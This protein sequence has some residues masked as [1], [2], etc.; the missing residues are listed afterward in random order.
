MEERDEFGKL[1]EFDLK[2]TLVLHLPTSNITQEHLQVTYGDSSKYSAFFGG[3]VTLASVSVKKE[4]FAPGFIEAELQVFVDVNRD[5]L[6]RM[7]GVKAELHNSKSGIAQHYVIFNVSPRYEA[8]SQQSTYIKLFIYSPDKLLSFKKYNKCYVAK[9]FGADIFSTVAKQAG[10]ACDCTGLQ[11]LMLTNGKEF[12]QPYL[13][14]YDETA[15]HF[16]TRVANRCGEFMYYENGRWKLG[17]STQQDEKIVDKYSSRTYHCFKEES[18]ADYW[19][20]NYI[21][22]SKGSKSQTAAQMTEGMQNYMGPADENMI[23]YEAKTGNYG[24]YL[25]DMDFTFPRFYVES[26]T[27]WLK[28]DNLATTIGTMTADLAVLL[29]QEGI[30][31]DGLEKSWNDD[32]MQPFLTK[33]EHLQGEG[34]DAKVAPFTNPQAVTDGFTHLFYTAVKACGKKAENGA[35]HLDLGKKYQ[36][37]RLGDIITVGGEKYVVT[38]MELACTMKQEGTAEHASMSIDALPQVNRSDSKEKPDLQWYPEPDDDNYIRKAEPQMAVVTT[39]HNADPMEL[40]RIQI[41]YPWQPTD[42]TP[43][44]PWIRVVA[45]FTSKDAAVRFA[46]KPGNEIMVGYEYGDIERPFMMGALESTENHGYMP[47]DFKQNPYIIATPNGHRITFSNPIPKT[48]GDPL[49]GPMF[50]GWKLLQNFLPI[51][52]KYKWNKAMTSWISDQLRGGITMTDALGFYKIAMSTTNRSVTI[53]SALGKVDLNALTGITI[54]APNGNVK[55][56]GKNVEITAGNNLKLTSGTNIKK[57]KFY[58]DIKGSFVSNATGAFAGGV[59]SGLFNNFQLID[60]SLIRTIF[61]AAVKPVGGT[62]L[63]KSNRFLRLEAGN[64]ETKLPYVNIQEGEKRADALKKMELAS[65]ARDVIASVMSLFT[66]YD[67]TLKTSVAEAALNYNRAIDDMMYLVVEPAPGQQADVRFNNERVA[68]VEDLRTRIETVQEIKDIAM[69]DNPTDEAVHQRIDQLQVNE[70]IQPRVDALIHAA[71]ALKNAV[72]QLKLVVPR[73]AKFRAAN[74]NYGEF[75][76]R[77]DQNKYN[78]KIEDFLKVI[79]DW[80]RGKENLLSQLNTAQGRR[81]ILYDVLNVLIRESVI[82]LN[83][84]TNV[85]FLRNLTSTA[86]TDFSDFS[87][88][89]ST[90]TAKA[91][92]QYLSHVKVYDETEDINSDKYAAVGKLVKDAALHVT[93]AGTFMDAWDEAKAINSELAGEIL[94]S[95]TKGN[96]LNISGESIKSTPQDP[97]KGIVGRM[98]KV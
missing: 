68:S 76:E 27:K 14:Q 5:K 54:S 21:D 52:T 61:E 90:K 97:L 98:K 1:K 80:L 86:K 75:F 94:L 7:M 44:S 63:I 51:P 46:P 12:M 41:R 67:R 19:V 96:T 85:E 59:A 60:F 40:G 64:G 15:L 30:V 71:I 57:R 6:M 72:L 9:K 78:K 10:I 92:A 26:V 91:W 89:S 45:P 43:A 47:I 55:I 81:E 95:D 34:D 8:K 87:A 31:Y 2:P 24:V 77:M 38:R 48:G 49:F 4:M 65:I 37:I 84:D 53:E 17:L 16:L 3:N 42:Q 20:N 25:R 88:E 36:A 69:G 23:S 73:E 79:Y 33:P 66:N 56:V 70:N 11:H 29:V 28:C 58:D 50:T 22:Q 32:H 18:M 74:G 62:T 93:G 82:T 83:Y 35:I 39:V 13:V